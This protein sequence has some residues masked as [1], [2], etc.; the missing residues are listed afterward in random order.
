[1]C[2]CALALLILIGR[3][4]AGEVSGHVTDAAGTPV[5]N[6][7]IALYDI[8][9]SGGSTNKSST[10]A[11]MDQRGRQFAPHVL[12]IRRGTAVRFPN[13]DDIRHQVY[14][15]SPAKRFTLP[16]YHGVPAKPETFDQAGEVVLGCNIHDNMLG[17]IYVVDTDWF[18]KTDVAGTL[19]INAVPPGNYK[20]Q[21]WYPGLTAASAPIEKTISVPAVGSVQI[22]FNNAVAET[23][24]EPA[25]IET[26]SWGERRSSKP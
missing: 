12:V 8:K 25:P 16:L 2:E 24:I 1:M 3:V 23:I 21:L 19:Q 13:S 20:A 22:N 7:V 18:A 4:S 9:N 26:R 10:E 5:A 15:F 11:V 14:S 17:Y 6:A